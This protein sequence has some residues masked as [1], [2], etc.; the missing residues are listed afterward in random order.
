VG[1]PDSSAVALSLNF[2]GLA[3]LWALQAGIEINT[4]TKQ[5]FQSGGAVT[6]IPRVRWLALTSSAN[7]AGQPRVLGNTGTRFG[8]SFQLSW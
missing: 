4:S 3:P 1:G 7:E 6:A 5:T 8:F 2:L